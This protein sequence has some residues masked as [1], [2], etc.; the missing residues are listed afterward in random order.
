MFK[1]YFKIAFRHLQKNKLY[2]FVNILG[3]AIGLTSCILIGIYIWQE[4]SYDRFHKNADRIA[5]ITWEYNF[6]DKTERTELTGTKV[7]PALKRTL[8]EVESYVRTLKFARVVG[9]KDRLF[10]EKN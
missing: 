2:A 1:N 9:Y 3:L 6:G 10:D 8:P 5:R 4:L 7:G